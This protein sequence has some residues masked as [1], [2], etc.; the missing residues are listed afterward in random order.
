MMSNSCLIFLSILYMPFVLPTAAAQEATEHIPY[1]VL[2]AQPGELCTICG[3][4]LTD[5]DVALQV[6]GRRVPLNRSM[7][8]SFLASEEKYFAMKQPRGALFSEEMTD[9]PGV[10]LGGIS[11]GWFLFGC[12]ILVALIFSGLS[13]YTAVSKGL[14][15]IQY[16]FIGLVFSVLGYIYVLTRPAV[17]KK[18]EIP[19]G[20][21]KVPTTSA[22]V[23]CSRCGYG[24]HPAANVC[25]GCGG[26]LQPMVQSEVA[27][28]M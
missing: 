8:D 6:R 28:A 16:F 25:A 27:R 11:A 3:V 1:K 12:Y 5:Q 24:N 20:L 17:S 23:A 7:V 26:K 13:G 22:P 10:S 18:G 9:Q 14:P 21:V 2:P 4:P 15:P 19:D